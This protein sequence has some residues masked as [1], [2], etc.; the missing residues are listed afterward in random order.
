MNIGVERTWVDGLK[1]YAEKAP[2]AALALGISSGFPYAMIGAT[3]AT[4]LAQDGIDKKT[5]TAFSLALLVYSFKP[6][7]AWIVDGVRL[8]VLGRLGQRVS[9]LLLAGALVIAAVTNLAF[10]NP[11]TSVSS[12]VIAAIFVGAAGATFDIVIDAYR[13]E[14]LEPRQLGV[15]AGMSQYGWRIGSA[16]A[17]A[18]ALV[19]AARGGWELAYLVCASLALPAM[20]A[21]LIVGEP[22]RHRSPSERTGAAVALDAIWR[23]FV[24]FFARPG[25]VVIL[26]FILIHKIGDTLA[27]LTFRLLFNDLKFTN[28]EI[29]FYDVGLG[30]WAYMAGIF[31][32]GILY[33]RMGLKRSV[34]LALI[35]MAVS[36]LSFAALAAAGHSNLGMAGAIGFENFASGFGGVAVVAYFSALCDLRFTAA[37]YALISAA[38]SILGRIVTGTTAGALIEAMGYVNFY[39]FTTVI[40]VPGVLLF[41]WMSHTGMIDRSIGSAGTTGE[42]DVREEEGI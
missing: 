35:L 30:F 25:A 7:W 1:P 20:L 16:G 21:G 40:A 9:W 31:A 18:L 33:A 26:A 24:Q 39:L 36:N 29:A 42:G 28:D 23:P 12:V 13:I 38:A 6:L 27:N 10:A 5:V 11:V 15:G 14:I 3:L 34:L 19:I 4:R 41:W 17:G 37:Q 8:P 32:G 2:L 22:E